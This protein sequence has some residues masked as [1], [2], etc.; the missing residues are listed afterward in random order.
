MQI[1]L[2]EITVRTSGGSKT[3]DGTALISDRYVIDGDLLSGHT[4]KSLICVG[5]QLNV[6]KSANNFSIY[7]TDSSGKD[8]TSYY[9]INRLC[10]TL[11]VMPKSITITANSNTK[12]YD[13]TALV[14]NGYT[15][16][17][18]TEGYTVEIT[19]VGSQTNI[20]YSDNIVQR[21]IVKDKT[22]KDVTL[23][24]SIEYVNGKLFVTPP[25]E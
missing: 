1:Y 6:G 9:K 12:V 11:T 19:V 15:L 14:D 20:G 2:K 3:Y 13:G 10:G 17:G 4:L 22:G 16:E 8:V 18:D 23:N 25:I 5:K 24:F 7:I 21:V